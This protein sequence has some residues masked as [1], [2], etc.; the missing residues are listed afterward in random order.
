MKKL[1]LFMIVTMLTFSAY[2][3]SKLPPCPKVDYSIKTDHERF[4]KWHNCWGRYTVEF[5]EGFKGDVLEG[6]WRNSYL[7][8]QGTYTFANGEKYVGGYK[9]GKMDG[10]GTL[11][12]PNGNKYIGDYKDC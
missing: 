6:E 5:A 9:D 2:G 3:Q 4:A 11:T 7:N 8:G 1:L 10:Q 12:F